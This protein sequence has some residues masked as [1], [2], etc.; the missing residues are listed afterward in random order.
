MIKLRRRPIDVRVFYEIWDGYING[1]WVTKT[2]FDDRDDY[3][4]DV[5]ITIAYLRTL[6]V[7]Y[8]D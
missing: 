8:D 5:Q 4:E 3:P 7:C 1:R 6:A 2:Y